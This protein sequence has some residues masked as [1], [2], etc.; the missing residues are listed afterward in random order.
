MKIEVRLSDLKQLDA[1]L[2]TN[3]DAIGIGNE[4]CCAKMPGLEDTKSAWA[5]IKDAGKDFS[6]VTPKA[7]QRVFNDIMGYIEG[8]KALDPDIPIT[9]NDY[10]VMTALGGSYSNIYL[11]RMVIFTIEECPWYYSMIRDETPEIQ[12]TSLQLNIKH[13]YKMKLF[14][15]FN[16]TGVE[17]NL[18]P[19]TMENSYSYVR[20][21]GFKINAYYGFSTIAL[22]RSCHVR[23]Y[24]GVEDFSCTDACNEYVMLSLRD[25]YQIVYAERGRGDM[26]NEGWMEFREPNQKT[27]DNVPELYV[28]GNIV[29]RKVTEM[30][31]SDIR[32][33]LIDK[34]LIDF[35]SY[36]LSKLNNIIDNLKCLAT[37]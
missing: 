20:E 11:G 15:Q 24:L 18:L 16:L 31:D 32:A 26:F 29:E 17:L 1:A 8:I 14:K 30:K 22:S 28:A 5:K 37:V 21:N 19:K 33:D 35:R 27:K 7:P 34:V 23:R 13:S 36:P 9:V 4:G 6:V 2:K 10:G 3:C 12:E 25:I